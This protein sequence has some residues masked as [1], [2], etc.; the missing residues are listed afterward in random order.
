MKKVIL[1]FCISILFI[2]CEP[3]NTADCH[4][5]ITVVNKT[6]KTIYVEPYGEYPNFE[7]YK[8]FSD[9]LINSKTTKVEANN[10][11]KITA[12]GYS[13]F[14]PVFEGQFKSGILMLYVFDGPT[15]ETQGWDYIKEHNL[16]LKRYDLTLQDVKN[17][18]WTITYDGN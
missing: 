1:F 15:L 8:Y 14:E 11:L 17:M 3:I 7:I 9:P 5:L 2:S 12:P 4:K 16:V 13:C 18:N 10:T 6:N